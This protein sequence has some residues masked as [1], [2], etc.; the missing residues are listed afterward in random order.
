V[1]REHQLQNISLDVEVAT[2]K[3]AADEKVQVE[4]R[5]ANAK[6]E[7]V[8]QEGGNV[9]AGRIKA[10]AEI[11][12][13]ELA[14]TTELHQIDATATQERDRLLDASVRAHI[15]ALNAELQFTTEVHNHAFDLN[16]RMEKDKE[17][18]SEA[19]AAADIARAGRVYEFEKAIV[20]NAFER[21]RI[22]TLK[23]I[24]LERDLE[25]QKHQTG[26]AD[27]EGKLATE[28]K[29]G[30]EQVGGNILG[31]Q[32]AQ[33]Q[34][35]ALEGRYQITLQKL[36]LEARKAAV[37]M[38]SV[39]VAATHKYQRGVRQGLRPDV[40]QAEIVC[41]GHDVILPRDGEPGCPEHR[42]H[43]HA[44]AGSGGHPEGPPAR[45]RRWA[46]LTSLQPTPTQT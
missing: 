24:E 39:F 13:A 29:K 46:R 11:R 4:T 8:R 17:A 41:P 44:D 3:G 45:S 35:D 25:R 26:L 10:D 23:K 43:G 22:T 36:D 15:T 33:A 12:A 38:E 34:L 18:L 30:Q 42:A 28:K 40:E 14:H 31:V 37:S 6:V 1:T 9:L 21:H 32:A 27:A 2:L 7:Q 20:E 5:F 19:M 16:E